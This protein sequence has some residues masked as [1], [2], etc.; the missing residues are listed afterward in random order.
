MPVCHALLFILEIPD[1]QRR[2]EPRRQRT[3]ACSVCVNADSAPSNT[4]T[5]KFQI[6]KKEQARSL[7]YRAAG[8]MQVVASHVNP[9]HICRFIQITVSLPVIHFSGSSHFDVMKNRLMFSHSVSMGDGVTLGIALMIK[10][11]GQSTDLL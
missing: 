6:H 10:K 3:A 7:S 8:P 5:H 4:F 2:S 1:I 9:D 11:R